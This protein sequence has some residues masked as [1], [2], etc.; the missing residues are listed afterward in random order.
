MRTAVDLDRAKRD[1]RLAL[2]LHFYFF[3]RPT[4][5]PISAIPTPTRTIIH[6]DGHHH[7]QRRIRLP[8]PILSVLCFYFYLFEQNICYCFPQQQTPIGPQQPKRVKKP[9]LIPTLTQHLTRTPELRIKQ[10]TPI[11]PQQSTNAYTTDYA[12]TTDF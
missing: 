10:Q 9:T 7:H 12:Y 5:I 11:V 8:T 3:E 4:P 1:K 6:T 2:C